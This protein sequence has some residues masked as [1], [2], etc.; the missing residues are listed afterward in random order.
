MMTLFRG[1]GSLLILLRILPKMSFW[2]APPPGVEAEGDAKVGRMLG[3][4]A[5]AVGIGTWI[6]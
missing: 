2:V 1:F 5:S 3:A 4:G 6:T